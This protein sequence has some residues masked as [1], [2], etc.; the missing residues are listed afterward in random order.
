MRTLFVERQN[1]EEIVGYFC[2]RNDIL[3]V[4]SSVHTNTHKS[5]KASCEHE[6][7]AC[8]VRVRDASNAPWLALHMILLQLCLLTH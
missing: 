7:V 2:R 1:V 5:H 6:R 8:V 4:F 3:C